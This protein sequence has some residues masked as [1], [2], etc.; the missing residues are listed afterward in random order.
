MKRI[1]NYKNPKVIAV[2]GGI[3]S[4]QSTVCDLFQNLG[5]KIIDV[6]IKAK[7]IIQKD[8]L[9]QKDLKKA[10]GNEI[11]FKDGKLNRKHLAHLAFR[12]EAK[13]LELNKIIH[14]RMVA[15]VIEEMETARFS[16]R[17]PLII[18]DAALIFEISI[19]KMF[20]AVIVVFANLNNRINRVMERDDLKRTEVLARV[21]RQI[22]LE[23]KKAWADFVIDNNGTTDDLKKQTNKIF[24]KLIGDIQIA[25]RIRI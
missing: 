7:Q 11:F 1:I 6:D 21:R 8:V 16:Q 17:Y 23:E 22:P 13:T 3:G 24:E 14:P 20:D 15:E 10:F 12:D 2:T 19:E 5:C 4:G 9:L 25:K 18:V